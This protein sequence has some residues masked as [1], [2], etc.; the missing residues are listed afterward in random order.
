MGKEKWAM[1]AWGRND[2]V[3]PNMGKCYE[4]AKS[5]FI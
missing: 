5:K 4:K 3:W 1:Y 2:I